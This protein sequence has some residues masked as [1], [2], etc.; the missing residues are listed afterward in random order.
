MVDNEVQWASGIG[1]YCNATR[2][3]NLVQGAEGGGRQLLQYHQGC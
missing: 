2:A 3:A 1:N